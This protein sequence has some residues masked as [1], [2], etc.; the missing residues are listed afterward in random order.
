M[1]GDDGQRFEGRWADFPDYIIGITAEIWDDREILKI[2]DYYAPDV[3]VRRPSGI[4]EGVEA[5]VRDT[6]EA[7]AQTTDR[8]EG[9]EDVIWTADETGHHY[10]SHRCC[11]R[12][13]HATDDVYGPA[14]GTHLRYWL[15][16]DCAVRGVRIDDEWLVSD[17]GAIARQLGWEPR[18]FARHLVETGRA[19]TPLTRATDRPGPYRSAGDDDPWGIRYEAMLKATMAGDLSAIPAEYDGQ[20]HLHY[21]GGREG[22]GPNDANAFWAGLR[23]SFPA[24]SF[25]VHHRMG[26]HD[27][28]LSPRA[29]LRW[30]LEGRHEGW[31]LF[32]EPTGAEVHVMGISH[33]E[34]GPRGLRREWAIYDE[35]AIWTQIERQAL[36]GA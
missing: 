10:S 29:A 16:A 30:S 23:A 11:D 12:S 32:G 34:F 27:P 28:L 31:G 17:R 25:E 2:H 20:C 3:I 19:G 18:A 1:S 13:V 26:R 36:G 4:I 8:G 9:A 15:A 21:P 35:V 33:A 14:T 22:H 6:F 5:V 7:C 24:A